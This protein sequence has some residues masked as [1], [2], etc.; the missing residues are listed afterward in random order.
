MTT[1][2]AILN[3]FIWIV[4]GLTKCQKVNG[5]AQNVLK[6]KD[7]DLEREK[8]QLKNYKRSLLM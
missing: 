4:Y 6:E 1:N 2:N 7:L 8:P 3:G 5:S